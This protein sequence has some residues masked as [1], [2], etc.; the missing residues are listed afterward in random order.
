MLDG[1]ALAA[2]RGLRAELDAAAL[3]VLQSGRSWG[4]GP[5]EFTSPAPY[6]YEPQGMIEPVVYTVECKAGPVDHDWQPPRGWRMIRH[7]D[8]VAAGRPGL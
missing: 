6:P 2:A 1:P 4:E 7:A 8:W 5:Y 3:E